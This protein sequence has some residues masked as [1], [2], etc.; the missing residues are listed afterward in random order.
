MNFRGFPTLDDIHFQSF[1]DAAFQNLPN[2][3]TQGGV[4]ITMVHDKV[5]VP[6]L[7]KSR[8]I[9]RV[10]K[11]TLAGE[12]IMSGKALD[13]SSNVRDMWYEIRH[14]IAP[15]RAGQQDDRY[16]MY[17]LGLWTDANSVIQFV[18]SLT[19]L[20]DERRLV[21]DFLVITEALESGEI[22][23]FKH[24]TDPENI[25]DGLTKIKLPAQR[26]L[27]DFMKE[28]KHT[29]QSY[30]DGHADWW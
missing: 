1:G 14:H 22:A 5:C 27:T 16:R 23:C 4:M 28:G 26:N 13:F 10:V 3:G 2:G 12:I 29:V 7:W 18:N 6:I 20:P 15:L 25:A 19:R 9:P 24:C 17:P 11:S 30:V 21:A 8:K